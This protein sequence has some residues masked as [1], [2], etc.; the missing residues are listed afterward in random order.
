MQLLLLLKT[1]ASCC[2]PS[3]LLARIQGE[4]LPEQIIISRLRVK[5]KW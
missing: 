2:L 4:K 3:F 5:K 1:N